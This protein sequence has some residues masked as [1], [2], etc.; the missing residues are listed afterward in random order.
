MWPFDKNNE[1]PEQKLSLQ[2]HNHLIVASMSKSLVTI[3]FD[4]QGHIQ[5]A[6][7]LFLQAMGYQLEEL[8]GKHHRIFC[9]K[10]Y[11]QSA[12]YTQFWQSLARGEVKSGTFERYSKTGIWSLLKRLT[13]P[14]L[15]TLV[16]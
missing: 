10:S 16:V 3:E 8:M 15:M 5:N 2:H 11:T 6:S 12:D 14:F 7:P 4:T 13:F 1:E 9:D